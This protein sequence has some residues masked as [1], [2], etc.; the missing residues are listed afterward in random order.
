MWL[1]DAAD[2][3]DR[4]GETL[5]YYHAFPPGMNLATGMLLKIGGSHAPALAHAWFWVLGLVLVNALFVIGR[6]A[7]SST[8]VAFALALVFSLAPASIYFEHLY[9]YE[10][11]IA[12]FLCL[13][14]ALFYKGVRR[15]TAAVWLACFAA[16]ALIAVTRST[17][18]L[19]WL[20]IVATMAAAFVERRAR[21]VVLGSALVPL[22]LVAGL[23]LKNYLLFGE[24][25]AS[26]F[27]PAS[28]TLATIAHLPDEV[29]DDWIE[30]GKLSPFAAVS[31]YA[32]PREYA[33][34][35]A[36]PDHSGWPPP[37]TRLEN[38]TVNAPNYNHWWLLEVHRARRRDV[39]QYLRSRPLD[40]AAN[41]LGNLEELFEPTTTW[42]PRDA[43]PASP[44]YRHRQVLGGYETWFNRLVHG[45]P[46]PPVGLYAFLP[47]PLGW[48]LVRA[49]LYAR[50]P[51]P[52]ER[53]RG[54]LLFL[55]LFQTGFVVA[56][57]VMLTSLESA[58]YRYQVEGFIWVIATL[59]LVEVWQALGSR[60]RRG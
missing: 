10:W 8:R 35:F 27:G 41:V 24:F 25:A 2:L 57:S 50:S 32:P 22:S 56:A 29:R 23:Y 26:T 52:D 19:V 44:H 5:L 16:C 43:T 15:P 12:T 36:T 4:L 39:R 18:H 13:A 34:F 47:V 42:H 21:R 53:A 48:A 6:G 7:G 33:Q 28:L 45:Y 14:A 60:L 46:F 55:L 20:A 49:R 58:R 1:A 31:V 51:D 30:H 11:P 54:A 38:P 9:L 3:R 59:F 37:L 40:Y 17:F